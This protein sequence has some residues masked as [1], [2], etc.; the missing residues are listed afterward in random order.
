M[1]NNMIYECTYRDGWGW[2]KLLD[3]NA[4]SSQKLFLVVD[5]THKRT[6]LVGAA[7]KK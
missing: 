7:C 2:S 5:L 3:P 6:N 1:K 4:R